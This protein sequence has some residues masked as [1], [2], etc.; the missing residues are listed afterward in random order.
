M[1]RTSLSATVAALALGVS[2]AAL[3]VASDFDP[4]KARALAGETWSKLIATANAATS[5]ETAAPS[6]TAPQAPAVQVTTVTTESITQWEEYTGRFEA[7][8]EVQVRARVS[9]YLEAV[10]FSPGQDVA[11]GDLLFT[12]DQRPFEARV[13]EARAALRQAEAEVTLARN[14]LARA[15][16][17][18]DRGHT[19]QAVFEQRQQQHSNAEAA[20]AA[21]QARLNTAELDLGFTEI[22]APVAGR[23][24]DDAVTPG[25]LIAGGVSS[26]VL[27]TIVSASPIHFVF[28]AT[29]QQLLSRMRGGDAE[30]DVRERMTGAEVEVRLIDETNFN[31][32]G[33]ID[34]I[35]NRL[36]R[37]T[38]TIRGRAVLDNPN[39]LLTPGMFGRMRLATDTPARVALIPDQAIGTDQTKKFVWVLDADNRAQR[40]VVELGSKRGRYRIVTKGLSD[41]ERIVTSGLHRVASGRAVSP[42]RTR[43]ARA[44]DTH[45]DN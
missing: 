21:A 25:N 7:V 37:L 35:D 36:D 28:D 3:A 39:G 9:G 40:R 22:R 41:G 44:A 23:I 10:H 1:S 20:V 16:Q 2:A 30:R 33:H 12:I 43:L 18:S 32:R 19:S 6:A 42:Q 45:S 17:L 15:R 13:A 11:K 38:G 5:D 14:E 26:P 34:F 29:E 24:S 27:T 4:A 31:H 8:D